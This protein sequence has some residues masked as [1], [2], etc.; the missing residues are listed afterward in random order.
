MSDPGRPGSLSARLAATT[1]L[2]V[3]EDEDDIAAF[4][5]AY[6]R[7]SG[8]QLVRLDPISAAEVV[9]AVDDH[10]PDCILL[11]YGLR[12][13]SGDEAYRLLRSDDRYAFV[14]VI[15]ISANMTAR[16]AAHANAAHIDAFMPKPF[17]VGALAT[18]VDERI[19]AAKELSAVGR[20]TT[21]PV[22]SHRYLDAR[23]ADELALSQ[24][25]GGQP[26]AL[27]LVQVARTHG[28][29]AVIALIA[30]LRS[31][32]PATAVLARTERQELA[33]ILPGAQAHE[34][35]PLLEPAVARSR[36]RA[37]VAGSPEHAHSPEELFMAADAALA[38]AV[39]TG[40]R[41]RLA[42]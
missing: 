31:R 13:F 36:A 21:L 10:E 16:A 15:V 2:L 23:L 22:M 14:P 7:A 35:S 39:G 6:F 42:L 37:G 20:D 40:E 29:D 30:D 38:D 9:A 19:A 41:V 8:Y 32:L 33:V 17:H 25:R 4:L 24:Q 27:A 26:L 5:R 34:L 12:G 3:V 11:D 18:L 28:D 1:T